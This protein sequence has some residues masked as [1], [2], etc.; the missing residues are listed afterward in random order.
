MQQFTD[1]SPHLRCEPLLNPNEVRV[2]R[3]LSMMARVPQETDTK[4]PPELH[5]NILM[6]VVT[7]AKEM[8]S[9]SKQATLSFLYTQ[10]INSPSCSLA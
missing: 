3:L 6:A 2:A 8:K 5:E 9:H 1:Q 4:N 7:P 10:T